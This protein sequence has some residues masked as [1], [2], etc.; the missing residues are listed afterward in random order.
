M[1]KGTKKFIFT[2]AVL[3][4]CCF[5]PQNSA[6]VEKVVGEKYNVCSC[7]LH[8]DLLSTQYGYEDLKLEMGEGVSVLNLDK[9]GGTPGSIS[10]KF[11]NSPSPNCE[12]CSKFVGVLNLNK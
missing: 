4:V 5:L 11:K 9:V 6:A 7:D 1:S 12:N 2:S 8:Y 10:I 3:L